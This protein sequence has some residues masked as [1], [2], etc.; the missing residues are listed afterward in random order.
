[1]VEDIRRENARTTQMLEWIYGPKT[2]REQVLRKLHFTTPIE[3]LTFRIKRL[4]RTYHP[5]VMTARKRDELG[6]SDW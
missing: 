3:D 5:V 2:F 4:W 1:M 6:S